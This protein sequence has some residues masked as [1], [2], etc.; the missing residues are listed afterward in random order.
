[1]NRGAGNPGHKENRPNNNAAHQWKRRHGRANLD[2][3]LG[4]QYRRPTVRQ[5]QARDE[6][7]VLR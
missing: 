6:Y 1:M 4:R 5:R 2:V 7:A 3:I